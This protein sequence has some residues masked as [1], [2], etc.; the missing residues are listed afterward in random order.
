MSKKYI[1]LSIILIAP[2][3]LSGCI[4]ENDNNANQTV[5][6]DFILQKDLPAGFTFLGINNEFKMNIANSTYKGV[7][8]VY[9]N[10]GE[11]IYI[12][13]IKNDNADVLLSKYKEELRQKFKSDYNPFEEITINGHP[14]TKFK[15]IRIIDGKEQ[16]RYSIMWA[17]QDYMVQVGSFSDFV[18]VVSLATATGY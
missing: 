17:K 9:R 12:Q 3:L 10:G 16:I 14:A 7:E 18:T 13:T 2:I 4:F 5:T 11:D 1:L 6:P 8:G 15:D